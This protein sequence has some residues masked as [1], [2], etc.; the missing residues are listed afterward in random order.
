[1]TW[2]DE[3]GPPSE[4]LD[5]SPGA[6][7]LVEQ[8]T[9]DFRKSVIEISRRIQL[10]RPNPPERVTDAEVRAA[11]DE[12]GFAINE[13]S[14]ESQ[15][16]FKR[17]TYRKILAYVVV[18]S[19]VLGGLGAFGVYAIN[20][21]LDKANQLGS[22]VGALTAVVGLVT[23]AY[24]LLIGRRARA[25]AEEGASVVDFAKTAAQ[26]AWIIRGWAQLEQALQE[27][28]GDSTQSAPRNI[29]K[30]LREYS[31]KAHLSKAEE[32]ELRSL[33]R[34]RNIISHSPEDLVTL[35]WDP[36]YYE[37]LVTH[38]LNRIRSLQGQ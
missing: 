7:N 11:L 16:R 10:A 31:A 18:A 32:E 29:N 22:V 1:M 28:F 19:L 5:F 13:A 26:E 12:L 15:V 24:S 17:S 25:L 21:G 38:H 30:L 14:A 33:L 34:L 2:D 35:D 20:A 8:S 37:S 23:A 27:R 6:Q 4:L 9:S 36:D 3:G